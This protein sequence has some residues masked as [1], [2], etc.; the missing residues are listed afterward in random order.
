MGKEKKALKNDFLFPFNEGTT[1]PT[2]LFS[3]LFIYHD[4]GIPLSFIHVNGNW[5]FSAQQKLIAPH[6]N[7][8]FT[9]KC[10]IIPFNFDNESI[11]NMLTTVY[12][13]RDIGDCDGRWQ[14]ASSGG[15]V[16]ETF[17]VVFLFCREINEIVSKQIN[18]QTVHFHTHLSRRKTTQC[19]HS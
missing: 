17:I 10:S 7:S 18:K 16:D 12:I 15:D 14:V 4:C 2:I 3:F 11:N 19:I 1:L 13:N 9:S 5:R 6:K 8:N